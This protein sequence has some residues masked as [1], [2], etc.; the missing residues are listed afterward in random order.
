MRQLN[1]NIVIALVLLVACGVLFAETFEYKLV[2]GAIIG[3]KIWP[4]IVSI[5][6]GGLSAIYLAQSIRAAREAGPGEAAA[7]F[8]IKAWLA[9]NRNVIGCYFLYALF[10]I[11]L[12]WLGMLLGG[13][14]FVFVT[15]SFLGQNNA[16]SHMI[17]LAVAVVT[18]G[19]MWSI[20]TFGLGVILPQGE[21]L[22][23]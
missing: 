15:L 16:R 12:K 2:P 19:C 13:M 3:S 1:H 22:P 17:N 6:L 7:P 18:I 4:R 10:L 5:F 21:I 9:E 23:R 8:D 14:L 11:S 20:F